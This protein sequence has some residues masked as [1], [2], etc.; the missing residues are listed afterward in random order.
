MQGY[1][2]FRVKAFD[3]SDA[4]FE[5]LY[6]ELTRQPA[7]IKPALGAK[8]VLA[9]KTPT[10]PAV[11]APLPE[12]P[13]LTTF[14]S[15]APPPTDISSIVGYAP[16]EAVGLIGREA[17]TKLIDDAWAKAVAGE[18]H[19]RVMTFVAL[20]GEGKSALVANWAN[21]RSGEDWPDC[22]RL[23]PGRSSARGPANSR[24][25]RRTSSSPRR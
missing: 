23:S 17:E 11:A 13:A 4:G 2:T 9:T 8:V 21:G 24:W 20:G 19:P 3:L 12:K 10:A 14:A 7:V 6:R 25:P 16:K 1:A 18:P 5:A 22:G 15:N